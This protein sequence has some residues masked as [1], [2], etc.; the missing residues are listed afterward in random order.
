MDIVSPVDL[1]TR[2]TTSVEAPAE[3]CVT[4]VKSHWA[5]LIIPGLVLLI[6]LAIGVFLSNVI[7]GLWEALGKENNASSLILLLFFGSTV[8]IAALWWA[9]YRNSLKSRPRSSFFSVP[10][11]PR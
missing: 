1:A 2:S 5:R 11:P 10:L 4:T 3:Q 8:L 9:A 6:W 7:G